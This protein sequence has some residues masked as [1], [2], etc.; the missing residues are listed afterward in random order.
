[1][2]S[3]FDDQHKGLA[4]GADAY[5]VKPI[6]KEWLL[7]TLESMLATRDVLRIVA[8]DD[9]EAY[10]FIISEM[11]D[12]PRFDVTVTASAAEG[13][14]AAREIRPD[15]VLLDLELGDM[16]G[17]EVRGH[18]RDGAATAS[19]PIL[20]V[21][22]HRVTEEQRRLLGPEGAILSKAQLTRDSLRSAI[23]ETV[24]L[25]RPPVGL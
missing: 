9:E 18:L 23:L 10:R 21:T 16:D 14:R 13:L 20:V 5:A 6:H 8:I 17:V 25:E 1:M 7:Q 11:L 4:L 2:I 19:I 22:S 3:T 15:V 24:G 12:D